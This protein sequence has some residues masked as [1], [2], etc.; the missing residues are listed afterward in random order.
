MALDLEKPVMGAAA[1]AIPQICISGTGVCRDS[2]PD[3]GTTD[4]RPRG[5]GKIEKAKVGSQLL[6]RRTIDPK[7]KAR[8]T[9]KAGISC[10]G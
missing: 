7:R 9:S 8:K 6:K 4:L 10:P 2:S 1:K 5:E 3:E